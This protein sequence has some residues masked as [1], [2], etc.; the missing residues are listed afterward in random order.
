[1]N[2][3]VVT[4]FDKHVTTQIQVRNDEIKLDKI[5]VGFTKYSKNRGPTL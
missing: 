3:T 4:L 5:H 2:I 1:M